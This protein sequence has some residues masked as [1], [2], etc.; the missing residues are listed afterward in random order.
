MKDIE[1]RLK[2]MEITILILIA[3]IIFISSIYGL[4]HSRTNRTQLEFNEAVF[5]YAKKNL[6]ALIHLDFKINRIE[7]ALD[8]KDGGF[9]F[10]DE[11]LK[12]EPLAINWGKEK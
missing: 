8:F 1:K 11:E 4:T 9:Y 3:V 6:D 2:I 7:Q 10:V 5:E 12:N